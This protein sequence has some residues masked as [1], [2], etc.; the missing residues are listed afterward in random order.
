MCREL[1]GESFWTEDVVNFT[2]I[3]PADNVPT[4]SEED[5]AALNHD[6]QNLLRYY[7]LITIGACVVLPKTD[8]N[9]LGGDVGLRFANPG[10]LHNARWITLANQVMRLYASKE[11]PGPV[12]TDLATYVVRVYVPGWLDIVKRGSFLDAPKCFRNVLANYQSL[13]KEGFFDTEAKLIHPRDSNKKP[14]NR[15]PMISE[16]ELMQYVVHQNAFVTHPENTLMAMLLD[17]ESQ[18]K[19]QRAYRYILQIR[20]AEAET[21]RTTLRKFKP[22]GDAAALWAIDWKEKDYEAFLTL[23]EPSEWTEPP[24]T[25]DMSQEQLW[26]MILDP[27]TYHLRKLPAHATAEERHVALSSVVSKKHPVGQPGKTGQRFEQEMSLWLH[28]IERGEGDTFRSRQDYH[29]IFPERFNH[30]E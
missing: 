2:P 13:E 18:A 28:A 10:H 30:Q 17:E 15:G 20:E 4:V 24:T 9:P 5:L 14:S 16:L 8:K 6:V 23:S 19:R 1:E 21:P 7:R 25:R 22:P 12:L 3:K 27:S 29:L 11:E 26:G